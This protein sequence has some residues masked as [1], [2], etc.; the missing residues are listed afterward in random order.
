MLLVWVLVFLV[1]VFVV[2]GFVCVVIGLFCVWHAT[3]SRFSVCS[4]GGVFW[5]V[6]RGLSFEILF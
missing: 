6:L 3:P 1:I 4:C 5:C 2:F